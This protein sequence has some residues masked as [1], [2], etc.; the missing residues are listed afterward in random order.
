[1]AGSWNGT[2]YFGD[3]TNET[4]VGTAADEVIWAD[5]GMDN[6]SGLGGNDTIDGGLDSAPSLGVPAMPTV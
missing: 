1:M 4:V 5:L 6:I 2:Q 3:A